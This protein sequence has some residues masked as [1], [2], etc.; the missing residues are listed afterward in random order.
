MCP[1]ELLSDNDVEPLAEGVLAVLEDVGILCQ[2]EDFLRALDK[3]G[4]RVEHASERVWFPRPL[5]AEFV[6]SLKRE[7]AGGAAQQTRFRPVALPGLGTQVAQFFYDY[8]NRERRSGNTQDFISL[9]ALGDVLHGDYGVGHTLLSTEVP[10]LLEPLHAALLLA[11]YAHNP[12]PPFAWNVKQAPYLEEM[13]HAL[14]RSDWYDLGAICI[15]HPLRFDRE[16]AARMAFTARAGRA[17]GLT[18]MPVAGASTPVTV[19]GFIV[20]S[21][22][23]HLA[24]WMAARAL[25][26]QVPLGGSMWAGTP[27]M[28]TGHV[29]YSAFDAMYYAFAAVEFLRKWCGI[30]IPV[31]GGEYCDAR[32]PGLYA[33]LEKAYKAMTIAAFTGVHPG[34]GEGMLDQ[35]KVISPVQLLLERDLASALGH[36]AREIQ[37]SAENI[38][39]PTIREIGLGLISSYLESELTLRRYRSCLWLPDLFDR[40]GWNGFARETEVLDNAQQK[41]NALL[42]QYRKPEGREE[43]LAAMRAIFEKARRSLLP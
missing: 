38:A 41:V 13:G 6:E 19:E 29:S 42:A 7:N 31:G 33:A 3:F 17:T 43:Q 18:A 5:V 21:S 4:A 39:L 27:D 26:P 22:A 25:S 1:I 10:P 11:E 12:S 14:G 23:E 35:G 16:V 24:A 34:I 36:F 20:V 30:T 32:L 8:E 40:S 15:A 37:P 9:I 2:N 28:R